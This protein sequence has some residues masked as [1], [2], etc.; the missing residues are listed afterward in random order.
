MFISS[1]CGP[2]IVYIGFS[3]IQIIIDIYKGIYNKAFIKF[4]I[5]IIFSTIINIICNLGYTFIAW[6]LVL[7]PIIMMTIISSLLL[8]VFGTNPDEKKLRSKIVNITDK[9]YN[10]TNNEFN[11]LTDSDKFNKDNNKIKSDV[12]YGSNLLNQQKDA[13]FYNKF[14]Q[15]ERIDRDKKRNEIYDDLDKIFDLSNNDNYDKN[16]DKY[17]LSNNIIKFS[18]VNYFL[19]LFRNG[20]PYTDSIVNNKNIYDNNLN[21]ISGNSILNNSSESRLEITPQY[22]IRLDKMKGNNFSSY[23]NKYGDAFGLDG[24][25]LYKENKFNDVK[26][27]LSKID[28]NVSDISINVEIERLWGNLNTIERSNW[29]TIAENNE[30][31]DNKIYD[32]YNR[33][34]YIRSKS[35]K[36]LNNNVPCPI[37]ETPY[38]YKI[39]TGQ[40]CFENCPPGKEKNSFGM[41]VRP[42]PSGKQR[43]IING[44]CV[45]I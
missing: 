39:K 18:I 1:L 21:L 25:L 19:N 37:N 35:G 23:S 28:P 34:A 44:N 4:I 9:D 15:V 41:C 6:I 2:A 22:D 7:I 32:F 36:T 40:T 5:M 13:Y 42:C 8:K 24:L 38:S 43:N 12:L 16:N 20:N 45:N 10:K 33:S 31:K 29:N 27:R 26:N 14:N 11:I 3:L 17:D 30:K